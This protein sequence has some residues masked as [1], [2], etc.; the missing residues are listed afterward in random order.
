MFITPDAEKMIELKE[1]KKQC[2]TSFFMSVCFVCPSVS[3]QV[4]GLRIND[5]GVYQC[6][7]QTEEGADY[8]D[9]HL[10]VT[11]TRVISFHFSV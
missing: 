5:S 2:C 1:E 6:L 11:G 10:S 9:I 8:K 4:S 3:R 7:V